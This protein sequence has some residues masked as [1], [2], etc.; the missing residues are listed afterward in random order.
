MRSAG[1][2][3]TCTG[4]RRAAVRHARSRL[5]VGIGHPHRRARSWTADLVAGD[6]SRLS[7]ESRGAQRRSAGAG[8]L[9]KKLA[10]EEAWLR[11]GVKAR[12]TRNEGRVRAL[13]AARASARRT[14]RSGRIAKAGWTR[15]TRP[16]TLVF[17]ADMSAIR[18][19]SVPIVRDSPTHHA[20]RPRR[21]DRPER[22]GKNDA[23]AAPGRRTE[24]D[25]GDH[26]PGT[27]LEVAY[28]DQQ[29]EQ[30]D[31]DRYVADTVNDGNDT[32]VINGAARHVIGYLR[33]LPVSART[34]GLS[35]AAA[36]GWRAQS[37]DAG[38]AVCAARQTCSC[39]T[40]QPTTSISKRSSSSKT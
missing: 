33:G 16:G 6:T 30:L 2:R 32:V 24:P 20:R 31:P 40:S 11:Q 17:E 39:S 19:A 35:G 37:A 9:D 3:T 15:A 4:S 12:R 1:S 7:E 23:A 8:R 14:R 13:M 25:D 26:P 36:V 28:F 21:S 38:A 29:R 34:R 18:S 10:K 22:F 27:G 5:P